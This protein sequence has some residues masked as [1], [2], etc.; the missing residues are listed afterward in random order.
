MSHIL[1]LTDEQ[2]ETLRKVA[3]RDQETPEQLLQRMVNALTETQGVVYHS[4]E[5]LLRAL[6]ADDEELA[7]LAQLK[8][9]DHA[10]A[11]FRHLGATD[12]QIAE[13]KRVARERGGDANVSREP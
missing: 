2:Y 11:W 8:T 5:E 1:E 3:A 7:E 4:D 13:A 6:G 12:E 10:D 9:A